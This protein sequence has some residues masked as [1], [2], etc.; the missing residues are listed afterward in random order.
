MSAVYVNMP[1]RVYML[2]TTLQLVGQRWLHAKPFAYCGNVGP[3]DLP[4]TA[5]QRLCEV[6]RVLT[7]FGPRFGLF[8]VDFVLS[9]D[10]RP[11]VIEVNPRYPASVEVLEY[12]FGVPMLKWHVDCA[13]CLDE[14]DDPDAEWIGP[15]GSPRR[16]V[17][18]K[19]I[20]YAPHRIAFPASGPWDDSARRAADVW[21][22][23][24]FA[25]VPHRGEVIEAGHPVLTI[26]TEAD[27][28]SECLSRLQS[29]AAELDRLFGFP[30]PEGETC[31]P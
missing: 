20:Y 28:E 12:G 21:C 19:A 7:P 3:W 6:G 18:G 2:G 11:H 13:R 31:R 9:D 10:D 4:E 27:T 26:L 5:T 8:G 24:D 22:R 25:D 30:T 17:V 23:P 14:D 15:T 29:R 16:T 1:W